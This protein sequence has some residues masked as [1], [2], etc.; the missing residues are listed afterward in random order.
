MIT[1]REY[2]DWVRKTQLLLDNA[3]DKAVNENPGDAPPYYAAERHYADQA[4]EI[5]GKFRSIHPRTDNGRFW[6]GL[7]LEDSLILL[8]EAG[9]AVTEHQEDQ[10]IDSTFVQG[11]KHRSDH[12][13]LLHGNGL[14]SLQLFLDAGEPLFY[15]EDDGF[16]LV[17][18]FDNTEMAAYLGKIPKEQKPDLS[19][20]V[21]S[22]WP[23]NPYGRKR[24]SINRRD[25]DRTMEETVIRLMELLIREDTPAIFQNYVGCR[26][27]INPP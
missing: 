14:A 16:G 17:R 4:I 18:R 1:F 21:I 15:F 3:W 6:T 10:E 2:V 7:G 23:I 25:K 13:H 26:C 24:K 9:F 8:N 27:V 22:S 19:F 20:R 5:L 12:Y 11:E